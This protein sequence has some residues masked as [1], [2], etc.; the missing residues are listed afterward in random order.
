L[1]QVDFNY[2]PFDTGD[3]GETV[4]S[5]TSGPGEPPAA[6]FGAADRV[7]NVIDTRQSY[8]QS[9]VAQGLRALGHQAEADRS[10]HFA[11]EMVALTPACCEQLGLDLSERDRQ[12]P[13]VEMSGRRGLGVK[14]DDLMGTLQTMA[15][16]EVAERHG[17][18]DAGALDRL[19]AVIAVGCLRYFMI[20]FSRGKVVAFDFKEALNFRGETGAYLQ[21]SVV[22][23]RSI[24]RKLQEREGLDL[25]DPS[26]FDVG[27]ELTDFSELEEDDEYW[28]LVL[29]LG[30]LDDV[31]EG[32]LAQLELSVLARYA[33]Q[34]AQ[35]FHRI[36]DRYRILGEP[37]GPRR[38]LRAAVFSLFLQRMTEILD[39]MGIGVP[40][41][42]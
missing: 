27:S 14:A 39:L 16:R 31:L 2:R 29:A 40:E 24:F 5:T 6:G 26:A 4:W 33:F 15:R 41:R 28:E 9:I 18:L 12:R 25:S 34:T 7:I 10:V 17:E 22:R 42:M 30:R 32:T 37:P 13:F 19:A 36:Y 11:Y 8:L 38:S 23:V 3:A 35:K 21:N 1:L 20:K